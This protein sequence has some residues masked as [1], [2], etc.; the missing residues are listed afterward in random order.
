MTLLNEKQ[1]QYNGTRDATALTD[2]KLSQ[3]Y[4]NN[5]FY[6]NIF[7]S[8]SI[9]NP[10]NLIGLGGTP[11][12]Y[13]ISHNLSYQPSITFIRGRHTIRAGYDMR[14][15][16][17]A[18][19]GGG[20]SNQSFSFTN[21]FTQHFTPASGDSSGFTSGSGFAALLLGDPNGAGIK[22]SISPFYSQHYFAFWVQDDWKITP[23]LTL[24]IGVR[25]DILQARTERHNKLNYAFDQNSPSPIQ[26]PRL[27]LTGGIRFSGI[28]GNP[29]GSY[30]TSLLNIQPRFGAAYA[31]S[32]R[33]SL[34]LG[35]GE[36]FIN[37]EGNDSSNGFSSSAT[38]YTNT[39]TDAASGVVTDNNYPYGHLS[40][41]FPGYVQPTGSSLGLATTPGSSVNFE[42]PNYK[43]P[44]L[45]EYSVSLQQLLTRRDVLDISYSGTR[46]YNLTDSIDLNHVSAAW[47]AMCDIER[48][49]NRQLCDST[50]IGPAQVVNPF[51][52]VAAFSGSGYYTSGTLSTAALTR[53]YPQFT[54][55][56]QDYSN[57][58]HSWYNSL[59]VT[60]S[61]T[62]SRSL[63]VHAAYTWSKT[64]KAGQVV[65]I[66]NGVYG[67]SISANDTPNVFTFSSV[68]YLP[69]GRGKALLGHTNHFVDAV[70]G[71][72][73]ISPL[74]VFTSGKPWS[75]GGNWETT[76]AN[77]GV[78][79]YD[80]PADATHSYK[81]RRGVTPCV[82]YKDIDTGA[83]TAGPSYI[84]AGCTAPALVRQPNTAN[85]GYSIKPN[86]VYW[87]VRVAPVQE[88]DAS[89]SKRFAWNEKLTL[90][91]RLDAFNVLNHPNFNNGF[92]NDPTSVDWGTFS[93]GPS[94]PG[95][96]VR[97]L[98]ISGKL[99]W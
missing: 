33:T 24:N 76:T 88:F 74:Y 23:K 37:N 57:L 27:P 34:R 90:Q 10:Y 44:S 18:N 25:Y 78:S 22:Y 72:W 89:L 82:G 77:I 39:V 5:A 67:R 73:E 79:A 71:G 7:P 4:I 12:N 42:N 32:T 75:P 63:S 52:G 98:Q 26:V 46:A 15:Y 45:W 97:D 16:Q 56:T 9:G 51:K 28:N 35:F 30:A 47:N 95:T 29:R 86:V 87:G 1:G 84:A 40:D 94:G 83:F 58:V 93:K 65:D 17:Y 43:I 85:G 70:V 62:V 66:I 3:H 38:G 53:P 69:V 92:N 6:N 49:G 31:F 91:T 48:G 20:S 96:P 14:L 54:S 55:V 19:P 68:Y 81:R 61:H 64:M 13:N 21:N 60:A 80:L 36:M 2:L 59:Q 11:I 50:A 99:I 41:P 8:V